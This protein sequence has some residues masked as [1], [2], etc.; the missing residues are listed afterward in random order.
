MFQQLESILPIPGSIGP[1][2]TIAIT[3]TIKSDGTFLLHHFLGRFARLASAKPTVDQGSTN[4]NVGFIGFGQGL[5]HWRSVSKKLGWDLAKNLEAGT[6]HYFDGIGMLSQWPGNGT[7]EDVASKETDLR[8][9]E[10][11][12]STLSVSSSSSPSSGFSSRKA[13]PTKGVHSL[14]LPVDLDVNI[15]GLYEQIAS[16]LSGPTTD[17]KDSE[18]GGATSAT[19]GASLCVIIDDLTALLDW[20]CSLSA[21]LDLFERLRE[22]AA[23]ND[24]VIVSLAHADTVTLDVSAPLSIYSVPTSDETSSYH[25]SQTALVQSLRYA[26]DLRLDVV[27]LVSGTSREVHGQ[28]DIKRGPLAYKEGIK[29]ASYHYKMADNALELYP[30]GFSKGVI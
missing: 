27:S 11:S 9:T 26:A 14:K 18:E 7:K 20:G 2:Y 19:N 10:T 12:L 17:P 1:G 23:S 4:W 3:D 30:I 25:S 28:L 8:T 13:N 5:T 22:L 21:V 15:N 29:D 6:L 24:G 16:V